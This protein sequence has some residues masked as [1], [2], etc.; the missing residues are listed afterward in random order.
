MDEPE[1]D[2]GE[3]GR[4]YIVSER[5]QGFHDLIEWNL[6]ELRHFSQTLE[7]FLDRE[8]TRCFFAL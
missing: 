3:V 6:R 8:E 7:E 1:I 2:Y 5:G 4:K